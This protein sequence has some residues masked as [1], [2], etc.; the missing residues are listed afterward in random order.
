MK[1]FVVGF[2]CFVTL[3]ISSPYA[4]ETPALETKRLILRKLTIEDA[5]DLFAI[6]SDKEVVKLTAI[7]LQS[8]LEEAE[9][10]IESSLNQHTTLPWIVLEKTT[11]VIVGLCTF[12]DLSIGQKRGE[13]SFVFARSAWNKGYATETAQ[14]LIRFGFETLKLVR[15]QGSCHPDNNQSSRVL[16]KCG[17][18]Y[19]G[20]LRSYKI[21]QGKPSDRK[22]Y[23]IIQRDL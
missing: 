14:E 20:L 22:M 3:F 9:R 7:N 21:Q 15:I 13:I 10:Y 11:N 4:I 1:S 6:T 17:M 16:E 2:F 18:Q 23:A 8:T 5:Q 19:E 12:F